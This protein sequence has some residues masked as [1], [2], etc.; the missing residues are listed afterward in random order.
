MNKDAGELVLGPV[1]EPKIAAPVDEMVSGW[2]DALPGW[3]EP[4]IKPFVPEPPMARTARAQPPDLGSL[5]EEGINVT[6]GPAEEPYAPPEASVLDAFNPN[7]HKQFFPGGTQ[8]VPSPLDAINPGT[9]TDLQPGPPNAHPRDLTI[10]SPIEAALVGKNDFKTY[11]A[12]FG[13]EAAVMAF[14]AEGTPEEVGHAMSA[15]RNAQRISN[16]LLA[17]KEVEPGGNDWREH[18][19]TV[20]QILAIAEDK[21]DAGAY[22]FPVLRDFLF[23]PGSPPDV[24]RDAKLYAHVEAMYYDLAKS[25][26]IANM[27]YKFGWT[28]R[29]GYDDFA[30][31]VEEGLA[32]TGNEAGRILQGVIKENVPG[33]RDAEWW[34]PENVFE[35]P[36]DTHFA[37]TP[38]TAGALHES[39]RLGPQ[40]MAIAAAG[41]LGGSA[42]V[43]VAVGISFF[44][45]LGSVYRGYI[46]RGFSPQEAYDHANFY[47]IL[48]AP[49]NW[50]QFGKAGTL[51]S[52][53]IGMADRGAVGKAAAREI[54]K[55]SA[56]EVV[57]EGLQGAVQGATDAIIA[58]PGMTE[59]EKHKYFSENVIRLAKEGFGTGIEGGM[60]MLP[61]L[62]FVGAPGVRAAMREAKS[63]EAARKVYVEMAKAV[64][65]LKAKADP[66]VA[67]AFIEQ[68][69]ESSGVKEF[70]IDGTLLQEALGP[71]KAAEV[72]NK[73]GIT[74]GSPGI[75]VPL[76]TWMSEI[77]GTPE[78]ALVAPH[79]RWTPDGFSPAETE[80]ATKQWD[81]LLQQSQ[82]ELQAVMA[83][84]SAPPD[85]SN[86]APEAK[87][88]RDALKGLGYEPAQVSHLMRIAHAGVT[89]SA[90]HKKT[91]AA[92]EWKRLNIEVKSF[93]DKGELA[94]EIARREGDGPA[95][96]A[97][98]QEMA[99]GRAGY[100]MSI[101]QARALG[102]SEG[103]IVGGDP[104]VPRKTVK[105]YKLFRTLKSRPGVLFPLFMDSSVA[106][107]QGEWLNASW[108][109]GPMADRPGWHAGDVPAAPHI[110]TKSRPGLKAPDTR[111]PYQVWAEVELADDVDWQTEANRRAVM[112]KE[113][114]VNAAT[115]HITDEI[116]VG[117]H[118]RYKTNPNMLGEWMVSGSMK[119]LRVLSDADVKEINDAAGVKDLPRRSP[120]LSQKLLRVL[121]QG[122]APIPKGSITKFDDG[123]L[124][125]LFPGRDVGTVAHELFHVFTIELQAYAESAG[126]TER[127]KADYATLLEFAGGKFDSDGHQKLAEAFESYLMTGKAPSVGLQRAFRSMKKWML[128]VYSALIGRVQPTDEVAEVFGRMLATEQQIADM[129]ERDELA[130]DWKRFF[131]DAEVDDKHKEALRTKRD[132][133]DEAAKERRIQRV[134]GKLL[135]TRGSYKEVRDKLREEISNR[136]IYKA[137]EQL[138]YNGGVEARGSV[139]SNPL[140]TTPGLAELISPEALDAMRKRWPGLAPP[141]K[142][143]VSITEAAFRAG[144]AN[145]AEFA[146]M[147]ATTP[148]ID[149]A[150][151]Q[152]Y[153]EK[154]DDA[155]RAV[156]EAQGRDDTYD[157]DFLSEERMEVAAAEHALLIEQH[158]G[159]EKRR[160]SLLNMAALRIAVS[161]FLDSAAASTA[162]NV[163]KMLDTARK[164][165]GIAMKAAAAGKLEDAAVAKR[166]ELFYLEAALQA[167]K[168]RDFMRK[169]QTFAKD[170]HKSKSIQHDWQEQL[171]ALFFRFGLDKRGTMFPL[172]K[173]LTDFIAEWEAGPF[174]S[175]LEL[176]RSL[177][178][179][180]LT[181]DY[182]D[183]PM[184]ELRALYDFMAQMAHIG[185]DTTKRIK[186]EKLATYKAIADRLRESIDKLETRMRHPSTNAIRKAR[187]D[188]YEG[189]VA[190]L[191]KVQLVARELDGFPD[192]VK[193]GIGPNEQTLFG[194]LDSA[195][196][197]EQTMG[198]EFYEQHA[199][200]IILG[201]RKALNR[202]ALKYGK[203]ISE[204][205][206]GL[207]FIPNE[208]VRERARRQSGMVSWTP[209]RLLM[210]LF[211]T[212]NAGTINCLT[213]GYG[214]TETQIEQLRALFIA[215]EHQLAQ[216]LWDA[217]DTMWPR[218]DAVFENLNGRP[219]QKVEAQP[220]TVT[221]ADGVSLRM[222]GGYFPV[223]AD[224]ELTDIVKEGDAL[225]AAQAVA[226]AV[227]GG[228]PTGPKA[229]H[230]KKRVGSAHP[231]RLD[232]G[233]IQ[234]HWQDAMHYISHAEVM[235]DIHHIIRDKD[236]R[237]SFVD[238]MGPAEWDA[239]R[240]ILSNAARPMQPNAGAWGRL[241]ARQM[242]Y[243][244]VWALWGNVNS[245]FAQLSAVV[246]SLTDLGVGGKVLGKLMVPGRMLAGVKAWGGAAGKMIL[247][248]KE[249]DMRAARFVLE[250]P[251]MQGRI[252]PSLEK[253]RMEFDKHLTEAMLTDEYGH[254][255]TR[256]EVVDA[257]MSMLGWFD[258]IVTGP[259]Y[260]AL[261]SRGMELHSG[262]E[263]KA[264]EFARLGISS[265][266]PTNRNID[267][268]MVQFTMSAIKAFMMFMGP[269]ILFGG[270]TRYFYRGWKEKKIPFGKAFEHVLWEHFSGPA[271]IALTSSLLREGELPEWWEFLAS[272]LRW[273]GAM[274][275]LAGVA[276]DAVWAIASPE[277]VPTTRLGASSVAFSGIGLAARSI[278]Q[279]GKAIKKHDE[280]AMVKAALAAANAASFT[281]ALKGIP[282]EK[283]LET[284]VRGGYGL[285]KGKT[286]NPA[287][288]LVRQKE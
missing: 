81:T 264:R 239:W 112:T 214:Y 106:V 236:W 42:G 245:M 270:R 163:K 216:S 128:G 147:L 27:A 29:A 134:L 114:T 281:G 11:V 129:R 30:G 212:G 13:Y 203:V 272:T 49:F 230:M 115:A 17:G 63:V 265:A 20:D 5:L 251:L 108:G 31:A 69:G 240:A 48:S 131:D 25:N 225:K 208:D 71:E 41:L 92:A 266:N 256:E 193:D 66:A 124:L 110:G 139:G 127:A 237:A 172:K 160:R 153:K 178:D 133:S 254:R 105:A 164:Y 219:Q 130:G 228:R 145:V 142:G 50:F 201:I 274:V 21:D 276:I 283:V 8:L 111:D 192:I 250:D 68:V 229:F 247:G 211:N 113:G 79:I 248:F 14:G 159:K 37:E 56:A 231:V 176:P 93:K 137:I 52:K 141:G 165:S 279:G 177:E 45:E 202:L 23:F 234:A 186:L 174:A 182:R 138:R 4:T 243:G 205:D 143:K 22:R 46:D 218:S 55:T 89:I 83:V 80:A 15:I 255:L 277:P 170:A 53:V 183:I 77:V 249:G 188:K 122:E 65:E 180:S 185:R 156:R 146:Q 257:G 24:T 267:K 158:E 217:N 10:D 51:L 258:F 288:P 241:G 233:V 88:F 261:Y 157:E 75:T 54:V 97:L 246:N 161:G 126:A 263:A 148:T 224:P 282:V 125:G 38:E 109:K 173:Q 3:E 259:S 101:E 140:D 275:P 171:R 12:L 199:K 59:E 136:H 60:L 99:D 16:A 154:H 169:I 162:S 120:S 273:W 260:L 197:E 190:E 62:G 207:P 189:L 40:M 200:P 73:L 204:Q 116:P 103:P 7:L 67:S 167:V 280:A 155:E 84:A 121:Y 262:D 252:K 118:Y 213:K 18:Q 181:A 235:T 100:E 72:L 253:M 76:S 150:V 278:A 215:E 227:G 119:V 36:G 74:P 285:Y 61:W 238:R 222:R 95:S 149:E 196:S 187:Q 57:A 194:A 19:K 64:T 209:E 268:S 107:P 166:K 244:A 91:D 184:G 206:I 151:A 135:G 269:G 44:Q 287:A 271:L 123:Y 33:L 175:D 47:A 168:H 179:N 96:A 87:A 70:Y 6:P 94:A 226:G 117:G 26:S 1:E 210:A 82:S 43:P 9:L 58:E 284:I 102:I 221:T 144:V 104:Y 39:L 32:Q 98:M 195:A 220:Y 35:G 242:G 86:E 34:K 132:D 2:P 198:R 28:M 223:V 286:H 78:E 191:D 85:E 232:F 152:E 90:M